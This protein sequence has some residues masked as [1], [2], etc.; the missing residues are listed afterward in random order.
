LSLRRVAASSTLFPLGTM[1]LPRV[2]FSA[3]R[4]PQTQRGHE[5][6]LSLHGE[7]GRE[8]KLELVTCLQPCGER[9]AGWNREMTSV[10]VTIWSCSGNARV[11][12]GRASAGQKQSEEHGNGIG[13]LG[14]GF[15]GPSPKCFCVPQMCRELKT[16]IS[17]LL[18]VTCWF[19]LVS[20]AVC[21]H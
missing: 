1:V 11:F 16:P 14:G 3:G 4:R 15:F 5:T 13:F 9:V 17:G 8:E 19:Y 12:R 21:S 18:S 20:V 7:D 2:L 6:W 10:L